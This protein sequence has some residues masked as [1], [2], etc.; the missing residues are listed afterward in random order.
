MSVSFD[1]SEIAD[2]AVRSGC[3]VDK[4][5]PL[6]RYTTFKIGGNADLLVIPHSADGMRA[7]LG[8]CREKGVNV[9]LL[10]NG[11]NVLV[12]D[13]GIRGVVIRTVGGLDEISL[14]PGGLIRAGA[15]VKLSALC[16]FALENG[17]SGLE[18]MYGIP[19]SVGGAIYMN[20][21]AYGGEIGSKIL[22]VDC[23][24]NSLKPVTLLKSELALSYRHTAFTDNGFYI[25]GA[26]FELDGDT[27]I[28]IKARMDD[29]I[30][31]RTEKQPLE[32][33]SAGS[34]FKRPEGYFAGAL[35]EE[36]NLKGARV[37]G[38]EVSTK[39]AGFIINSGNASGA[40]VLRLIEKVRQT[41]LR[42]KGVTLETEVIML[43]E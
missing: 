31:R 32:Y 28:D 38:A 26:V 39:H 16:A 21:G 23:I 19:G 7:V 14:L 12:S 29:Y 24:D 41:V 33:P 27:K 11:S 25:T 15:G 1:Y 18:Y 36:C 3:E 34:T 4:N 30:A 8:A 37:G 5:V 20:S 17:L 22:S 42:E 9:T 40:D 43:G 10:G 6:S 35:I 2:L 13:R